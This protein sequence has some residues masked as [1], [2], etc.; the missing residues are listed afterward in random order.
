M[1]VFEFKK[2][3]EAYLFSHRKA[4]KS[5]GLVPTMGALHAGHLALV[6]QALTENDTVV[7]TIFVN[8]T[9]FNNS[10]DL[11]KYPRNLESDIN[12]LN[13]LKSTN[14]IV[15]APTVAD[16]YPEG[17]V[18]KSYDLGEIEFVMEGKFRPGHFQGVATIVDSLFNI[19]K[20]N[21]AY[22]GKKDYQ[23]LLIIK[24]LVEITNQEI[25][26][27]PCSILREIDGLAMSS[28]NQRLTQKHREA[29]PFIYKTLVTAKKKFGTKSAKEV[30]NWVANEFNKNQLLELEYFTIADQT[31]LKPVLRK[32]KFKKHRAFI[33]A[34]AGDIRLIDNIALN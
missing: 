9:Q 23:Q 27:I 7:V 3:L 6:K 32:Q 24:R 16:I 31:T 15:Y 17:I 26:I 14:I 2:D 30:T 25:E 1:K 12:L 20:P 8:P 18:S 5:I 21:K 4:A 10:D 29:A 11:I 33:A 19:V 28:R 34:F 22:F 13:T